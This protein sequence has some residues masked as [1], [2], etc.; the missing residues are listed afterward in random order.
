MRF[1]EAPK[2]VSRDPP[3]K[4]DI[5]GAAAEGSRHRSAACRLFG[6]SYRGSLSFVDSRAVSPG[7]RISSHRCTA[8]GSPPE[9]SDR[10]EKGAMSLSGASLKGDQD[11]S[12]AG[13]VENVHENSAETGMTI[14]DDSIP[15]QRDWLKTIDI[16]IRV[17]ESL[18]RM[19][20]RS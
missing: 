12:S 3:V 13:V 17:M 5:T 4:L 20:E 16:A 8:V 15:Y 10:M 18:S 1:F 11:L 19:Q 6:R 14:G 2:G 7:A 9:E